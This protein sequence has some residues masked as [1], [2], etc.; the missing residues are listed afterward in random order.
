MGDVIPFKTA[1]ELEA[2]YVPVCRQL[3][4]RIDELPEWC[5][6]AVGTVLAQ[7]DLAARVAKA[8]GLTL[9]LVRQECLEFEEMRPSLGRDVQLAMAAATLLAVKHAVGD[10]EYPPAE[11]KP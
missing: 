7:L 9:L 2:E 8:R 10:C 6:G 3:E 11:V 5:R 4:A 1:A